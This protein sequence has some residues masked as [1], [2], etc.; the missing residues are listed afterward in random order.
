MKPSKVAVK[1]RVDTPPEQ[2]GHYAPLI[3][4]LETMV[5]DLPPGTWVRLREYDNPATAR[6]VASQMGRAADGVFTGT[7]YR[8]IPPGRWEFRHGKLPENPSRGAVWACYLGP[9]S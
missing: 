6:S 9:K 2:N 7:S 4:Q 5:T 8:R 1:L 3:E